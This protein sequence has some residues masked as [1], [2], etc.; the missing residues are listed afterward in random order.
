[1][2]LFLDRR[3]QVESVFVGDAR[4]LLLP[5]F[6]RIR[7]GRGRFRGLRLVHT[8]LD[9]VELNEDDLTDLSL[10][11]LD[12]VASLHQNSEDAPVRMQFAHLVP[13]AEDSGRHQVE[14]VQLVHLPP[15]DFLALMAWLEETFSGADQT[16]EVK[17][18]QPSALLVCVTREPLEAVE[19]RIRELQELARTAGVHI[20]EV[21]HQRRAFPDP[22]HLV[23]KGKLEE[24]VMRAMQLGAEL[25]LVDP[26]MTPAQS[27]AISDSTDLK[28]LD[29][30]MLILDIFAQRAVSREGKLQVELAQLRYAL[31]RLVMKNTMM[32]RLAG[33]I[34]GRGPGE[35]KL[36]INRRRARDRITLLEREIDAISRR[37]SLTRQRR[38][39]RNVPVVAI[40]GYTNAGKST[41]L[42]SLTRSHVFTEDKL[43]A[44][45]DPTTRRLRFPEERELVLTDTVGFIRELPADLARAF[46]ATLEELE[47]ANLL[48]H[49]VDASEPEWEERLD[50][51]DHI[52]ADLHLGEID[53]VVVFNK[54]DRLADRGLGLAYHSEDRFAVSALDP[55]SCR[56]LLELMRRRLWR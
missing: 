43:F 7:A 33:G 44:T 35:T 11:R 56:P 40:V 15:V 22:K 13:A 21:V 9:S 6:G 51:V 52:L 45:L 26:D 5:D 8:H 25:L 47:D 12:L 16:L 37:R 18:G 24:I 49:L 30:T 19:G 38:R 28:V 14:P 10:L 46:R 20:L 27:R 29:R 34:G 41:L 2:G 31:P 50:A 42:N 4:R 32:S 3:G 54:V 23:G 1:M 48:I 53:R 39:R 36:E 55:E 17:P